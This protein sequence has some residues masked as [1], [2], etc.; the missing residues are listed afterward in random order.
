MLALL[1]LFVPLLLCISVLLFILSNSQHVALA[2]W[3]CHVGHAQGH[4]EA[5]WA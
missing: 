5:D 2:L 1:L 3:H 4:S